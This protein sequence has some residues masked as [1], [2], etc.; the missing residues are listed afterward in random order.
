MLDSEDTKMD[1]N[2]VSSWAQ[3]AYCLMR[4]IISFFFNFT[5]PQLNSYKKYLISMNFLILNKY[6]EN[7]GDISKNTDSGEA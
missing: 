1:G 2:S 4:L 5:F 6:P 7:K 3:I